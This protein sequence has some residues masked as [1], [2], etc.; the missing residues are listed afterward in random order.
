MVETDRG[1]RM[2]WNDHLEDDGG[3]VD[4]LHDLVACEYLHLKQF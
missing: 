4:F 2:G 1:G 3:F